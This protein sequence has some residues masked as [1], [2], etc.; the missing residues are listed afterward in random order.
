MPKLR[1]ESEMQKLSN[2]KLRNV[3]ANKR[4]QNANIW[5][6]KRRH[7]K[8]T[9]RIRNAQATHCKAEMQQPKTA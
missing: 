2:A 6:G 9:K 5:L 3:K 1:N 4:I 8:G 7:A